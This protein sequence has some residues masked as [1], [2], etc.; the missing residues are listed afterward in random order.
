MQD[1]RSNKKLG[2]QVTDVSLVGTMSLGSD[3]LAGI[4][5][6]FKGSCFDEGSD[7]MGERIRYLFQNRGYF[8]VVV[9]SVSIKPGVP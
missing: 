4:T 7:E 8:T 6:E 9:K 1:H 3:E 2:I 5:G